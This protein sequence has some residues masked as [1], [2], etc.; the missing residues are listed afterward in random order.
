MNQLRK[1]SSARRTDLTMADTN[2]GTLTNPHL[3]G[4]PTISV[5]S[6]APRAI[7]QMSKDAGIDPQA[8]TQE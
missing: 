7:D 3:Y 2:P 8:P 1:L 6:D 4:D 5:K